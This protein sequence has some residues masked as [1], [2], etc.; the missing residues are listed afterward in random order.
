MQYYKLMYNYEDCKNAMFIN[1]NESD[2]SFDRYDINKG[3]FIKCEEVKGIIE[4]GESNQTDYISNNLSW[5]I[6]SEKFKKLLQDFKI[7]N[8]QFIPVVNVNNDKNIGY[9]VNVMSR[10]DAFDE[11]KSLCKKIK[12]NKNGKEEVYLS[13]IKYVLAK[14]NIGDMDMFKILG[15]DIPFFVSERLKTEL[16]NTKITGCDFQKVNVS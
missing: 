2:L 15:H 5:L 7:G 10:V 12:F 4:E 1:I 14:E 8:I 13:V 9:L 3:E 11:K 16:L 6:I